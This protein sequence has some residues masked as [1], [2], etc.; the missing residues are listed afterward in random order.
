MN[1]LLISHI[2]DPDGITP[3]I[4]AKLTFDKVDYILLENGE[5]ETVLYNL[6]EEGKL[7]KY[8]V[9]YITD[10]GSNETIYK[11]IDENE[12][13]KN[14]IKLFDHHIGNMVANKYSFAKVIDVNTN[15]I[16]ES[17]TSLFYHHLL[18]TYPNDNLKK[19]SVSYF[20]DLVRQYDTWEWTKTNNLD[21]KKLANLFD[22]YER[23]YFIEHFLSFLNDNDT[24]Y[25][26]DKELFL[27]EIEQI[28]IN[29]YI[30]QKKENVISASIF[31]YNVGI[32]FASKY[33]SELG[34]ELA[35]YYE[36]IFDF[37]ILINI[38]RSVSYR[39][40]K[41]IDLNEIAQIFGGKGHQKASGSPLPNNIHEKIINF[42]F[43][44]KIIINK[45]N[46]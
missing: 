9:I 34:N 37:I 33:R 4:L 26:N 35:K 43:D 14:K 18:S 41:D 38:E 7:T 12:Q 27:L 36:E 3:V 31:G 5:L 39:G 22:I 21:A 17:A 1:V 30:R 45:N 8:D 19:E 2:A 6:I 20:V 28:K 23:D 13:I 40:V 25:F 29:N 32:V 42:I 44:N 24:F 10:L 46:Y 16:K 15:N 11:H